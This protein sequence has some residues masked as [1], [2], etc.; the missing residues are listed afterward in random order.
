MD[1]IGLPCYKQRSFH[2]KGDHP[3]EPDL[4][5]I[6]R[7]ESFRFSCS[8]DVPCF[9]ECCRDLNQFLTPFDILRLKSHLNLS[10]GEF[11]QQY[12]SQHIGPGSGLPIVT[13]KPNNPYKLTCPFVTE[14]GCRIY[15]NRPSSCRTYPLMR[16]VSR[17]RSTGEMTE[18]FMVLK[19]SH[20]HGFEEGKIRTVEQ[21]MQDQGV[22]IYNEINDRLM[23]TISMKNQLIPGPLDIKSRHLFYTALYNL[24]DF[25]SQIQNNG[26]MAHFK[27]DPN[28]VDEALEN[29]VAL[30][31]LAMQWV[32]HIL[33]RAEQGK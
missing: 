17:S 9:N 27:I 1:N 19:E 28:I 30:L 26:L 3:V 24:D 5:P 13:L 23:Q 12:T 32:E 6:C 29:D 10:S 15:E 21:W 22:V 31:D 25:K 2:L 8:P 14:T 16:S 20:C 7:Q 4:T 33:F 18:Q 11:L